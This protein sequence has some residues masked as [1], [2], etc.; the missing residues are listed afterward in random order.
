MVTVIKIAWKAGPTCTMTSLPRCLGI[1]QVV[2]MPCENYWAFE[3][4]P[5]FLFYPMI[6]PDMNLI[7]KMP[8]DMSN[9]PKLVCT[10]G[11]EADMS[12][13]LSNPGTHCESF[14]VTNETCS[15]DSLAW[16]HDRL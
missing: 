8:V 11:Q 5:M 4:V 9:L 7:D 13:S 10:W 6:L 1:W 16:G 2:L 12:L 14:I 15:I 3:M